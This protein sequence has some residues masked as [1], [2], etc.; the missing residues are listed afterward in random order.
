MALNNGKYDSEKIIQHFLHHFGDPDSPYQIAK[1]KRADK[2][3]PIEGNYFIFDMLDIPN[4]G[5]QIGP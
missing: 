3:Y 4:A 5:I 1:A 2:K